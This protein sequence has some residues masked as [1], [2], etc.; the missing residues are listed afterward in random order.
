MKRLRVVVNGRA[1]ERARGELSVMGDKE[2]PRDGK[3]PLPQGHR[4]KTEGETKERK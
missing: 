2:V 3:R 4:D 1:R